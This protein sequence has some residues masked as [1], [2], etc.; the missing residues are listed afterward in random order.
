MSQNHFPGC[1]LDCKIPMGSKYMG[2]SIHQK[3]Q[4]CAEWLAKSASKVNAVIILHEFILILT[5]TGAHD[6]GQFSS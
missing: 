1:W 5:E 4:G 2:M 3:V 6:N